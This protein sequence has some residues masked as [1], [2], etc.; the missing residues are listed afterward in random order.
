MEVKM[1]YY[2][3]V[4]DAQLSVAVI[5]ARYQNKWVFCRHKDRTTWEIPGGHREP[6]E[7]IEEAARRELWE[8]TGAV[9]FTLQP[10]WPYSVTRYGMLYFAEISELGPLPESSEIAQIQ[11]LDTLPEELTYPF[12]QPELYRH[13]QDWLNM[14]TA[15]GELWDVYDEDRN[16]TGRLHRRGEPLPPGE[17]H[18]AVH[19]WL[20]NSRGEYLLTK[21]SPNKG[22][23]NLWECT[24]GSALAGDDSLAAALREAREETG[25]LLQPENGRLLNSALV[26]DYFRDVWL[27][28]QEYNLADVILL[29][30]ET[31]DKMQATK[32]KILTMYEEGTLVPYRYIEEWTQW[33]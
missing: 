19:V 13:V 15:L 31:C 7:T 28:E 9:E 30:G 29:E 26:D 4:E 1:H 25:L 33:V 12:I 10:L 23:P 24:G 18:L 20:R 3:G 32:E 8:E 16:L 2:G 11:M 14:Q 27:F 21:R 5:A 6:E 17:Y 22:F